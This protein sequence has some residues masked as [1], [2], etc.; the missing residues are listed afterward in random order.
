MLVNGRRQTD[1][2]T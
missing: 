1:C 2:H